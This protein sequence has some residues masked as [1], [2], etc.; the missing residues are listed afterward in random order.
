MVCG[1]SKPEEVG[2]YITALCKV[3]NYILEPAVPALLPHCMTFIWGSGWEQL[4][5]ITIDNILW[6]TPQF[7]TL[8][9]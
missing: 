7:D 5:F 9:T 8:C 2:H 4:L 6:P 1:R 3:I